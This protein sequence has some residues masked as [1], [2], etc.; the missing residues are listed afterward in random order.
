MNAQ[1]TEKTATQSNISLFSS[2]RV[3]THSGYQRPSLTHC[4]QWLH[5]TRST[6]S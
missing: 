3:S 1:M 5:L 6:R 4:G 2:A